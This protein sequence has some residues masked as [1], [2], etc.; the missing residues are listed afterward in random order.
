MSNNSFQISFWSM[1]TCRPVMSTCRPGMST[2][3]PGMSTCRRGN[4]IMFQ[5][6]IVTPLHCIT[7]S[8]SGRLNILSSVKLIM[9][10]FNVN[11][12]S[13]VSTLS[14]QFNARK[15]HCSIY[16]PTL[17]TTK[18]LYTECTFSYRLITN[19]IGHT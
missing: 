8:T 2:C 5:G 11:Q 9:S 1:S 16:H 19:H 4:V 13:I 3:R 17:S 6:V 7:V 18:L 12:I 15:A 14:R 10:H